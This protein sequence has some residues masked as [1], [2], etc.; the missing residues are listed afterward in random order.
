M[1]YKVFDHRI[2]TYYLWSLSCV[3]DLGPSKVN[4][5]SKSL[6]ISRVSSEQPPPWWFLRSS[7]DIILLG[8]LGQW[9]EEEPSLLC[10]GRFLVCVRVNY[11][12]YFSPHLQFLKCG[13][14]FHLMLN[15]SL[16]RVATQFSYYSV[17]FHFVKICRLD[18]KSDRSCLWWDR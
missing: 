2:L 18:K 11:K 4:G 5:E 6:I 9:K 10:D 16:H 3:K 15:G 14:T 7:V 12:Y 17:I 13:F 1:F 8:L